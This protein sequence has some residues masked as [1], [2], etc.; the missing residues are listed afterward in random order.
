VI[1]A[2][3][4]E[5]ELGRPRRTCVRDAELDLVGPDALDAELTELLELR[6]R[7]CR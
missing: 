3:R 4:A 6:R 2:R 1:A 5:A 7:R